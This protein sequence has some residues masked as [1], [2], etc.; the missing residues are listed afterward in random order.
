[1]WVQEHTERNMILHWKSLSLSQFFIYLF[2][3]LW[4]KAKKRWQFN[5]IQ[6][7]S[8]YKTQE[9]KSPAP[10]ISVCRTAAFPWGKKAILRYL[11][12][13]R[14]IT[15]MFSEPNRKARGFWK[16]ENATL[17]DVHINLYI[18][19]K[20]FIFNQILCLSL[21]SWVYCYCHISRR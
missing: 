7:H 5:Y 4:P 19:L 14:L 21:S 1:M 17:N 11:A 8:N 20:G 12:S 15:A 10:H 18:Y 9:V 2:F 13:I 6:F 16:T 3:F